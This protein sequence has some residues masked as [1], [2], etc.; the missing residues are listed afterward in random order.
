MFLQSKFITYLLIILVKAFFKLE[1]LFRK[2]FHNY[3]SKL[4][5]YILK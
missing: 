2:K 3:Q 5:K 1:S 4:N